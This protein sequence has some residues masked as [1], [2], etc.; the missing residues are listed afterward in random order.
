MGR[1]LYFAIRI[2]SPGS[3]VAADVRARRGAPFRRRRCVFVEDPETHKSQGCPPVR[4]EPAVPFAGFD[5][6]PAEDVSSARFVDRTARSS[7]PHIADSIS[8]ASCCVS[9]VVMPNSFRFTLTLTW[10][11]PFAGF[12]VPLPRMSQALVSWTALQDRR[13]HTLRIAFQ[14]PRDMCR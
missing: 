4:P 9:I 3:V 5:V 12:N 8:D 6:P 10:L 13:R 2:H 14:M 1:G 11:T 7:S